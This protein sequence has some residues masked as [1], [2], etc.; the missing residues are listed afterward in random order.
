[1]NMR[2]FGSL[3]KQAASDWLEDRAPRLGAALAYYAVFSIAPLLLIA[4]AVA[5]FVYGE[6][7]A[8]QQVAD[9]T[10]VLVGDE[11]GR[12]VRSMLEHATRPGAG[13]TATVFG[14]AMLLFGATGLFVEL[15]DSLNTIWRV[16]PRPGSG[17]W[18][19]VRD[20]LLSFLMVMVIA[21]LL[22][23]SV[24]ASTTLS[25]V[26]RHLGDRQTLWG[27]AINEGVSLLVVALLFAAVFRMLPDVKIAWGDVWLGAAVTAVLFEAGKFLVG[28][29]LGQ[30]GVASAYGAAGSL[31]VLLVWLYYSGQIFLFGA[32]LTKV[33]ANRRGSR[34]ALQ[35]ERRPIMMNTPNRHDAADSARADESREAAQNLTERQKAEALQE[36]IDEASKESFPASD[37]PAWTPLTAVG[38]PQGE[39]E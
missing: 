35:D 39:P 15:Q 31:A 32:E 6:D 8:Q 13:V 2:T 16:P 3:L 21:L 10:R 36:V 29:Y 1:M 14:V 4:I 18:A 28:F 22:L 17:L 26:A 19:F 37:P 11:G 9:E 12:A 27:F 20:R 23:V 24:V 30:S 7:R 5:G 25:A 34:T 33:Y 38:P